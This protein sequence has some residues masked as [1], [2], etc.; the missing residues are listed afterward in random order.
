MNRI[1]RT[2]AAVAL[3]QALAFGADVAP[4][5][6]WTFE[7]EGAKGVW[8]DTGAAEGKF[9][10]YGE[11]AVGRGVDVSTALVS[12]GRAKNQLPNAM[13]DYASFTVDF[14]FRPQALPDAKGRAFLFD[15]QFWSWG[16]SRWSVALEGDGSLAFFA[17]KKDELDFKAVSAPVRLSPGKYHALRF[18]VAADGLF[19][20]WL[21]GAEIAKKA[22]APGFDK[23]VRSPADPYYP[24]L[25]MGVDD[26]DPHAIRHPFVGD[27]DNIRFYDSALGAPTIKLPKCDYS[28][29]AKVEYKPADAS[30]ADLLV[31]DGK[32]HA[33]T[34]RFTVMD[35]EGDALGLMVT[36]D[37]KFVDAAATVDFTVDAKRI[38]ARFVCPVPRGM[39][40]EKN[41]R[42]A[43]AGDG[44]ELFIRPDLAKT[45]YCQYSAN[46]AGK[47]SFM[48]CTAPDVADDSFTS[49]A[50]AVAKDTADGFE[51]VFTVPTD[52]VFPRGLKA[53]DVFSANFVRCGPTCS[54]LSTWAAV[55]GKFS[56]I[57]GFGK[58]VYGGSE[59][60]FK[61][62]LA[63]LKAN[64]QVL[65]ADARKAAV[66]A[67]RP[68]VEAV[69]A[70]GANPEAFVAIE[71]MFDNADKA[72]LQIRL[73]GMPLLVYE[74][75]D[76]WGSM[77]A[78]DAMSRPLEA[79]KMKL[80]RNGRAVYAFAVANLRDHAFLG[81]FKCCSETPPK[82]FSR[83]AQDGIAR[84]AAFYRG[85]P[86]WNRAGKE[87]YDPVEPLSMKTL[88]RLAP[89]EYAPMY[90]ELD[91][92]GLEPGVYNALVYLK[93]ATPG[94]EDVRFGLE[95]EVTDLDVAGVKLDKA[96]YDYAGRSFAGR[97]DATGG[98]IRLLCERDYNTAF[99]CSMKF[100]PKADKDG[101]FAMGPYLELDRQIDEYLKHVPREDLKLWIYMIAERHWY[102]PVDHRGERFPFASEKWAEGIRFMLKNF[103]AH[104]KEKYGIG[105]DRIW[106][107][108]VD[109]PSGEIEDPT[110][111]SK[112][113]VAYRVAQEIKRESPENLTMT[114]PLP[115]FLAS[116]DIDAA[117]AKLRE[118]YDIIELYR[119]SI[120]PKTKALMERLK[121][122]QVW[123]YSITTKET[124]AAK[125]RRDYWENM[126]DGYREIAAFWHMT[127]SAGGD[128]FDSTDWY[129]PG[130][131]DDYATLYC[132]SDVEAAI[133]SRRQLQC[134]QGFW[135][136]QILAALRA[137]HA[138]DAEKLA[139]IA[140]IVREAA[141]VG[142][143]KAMD[144]ARDRLLG[145]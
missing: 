15:Y 65:A 124:P 57:E 2:A 29:I 18:Q 75:N 85:F 102:D 45:A 92:R 91:A 90:L 46:A 109:E 42:N 121:F 139:A 128:T 119:P 105:P 26:T 127:Q 72:L 20:A 74:P 95:V 12:T 25:R 81:Q 107:Y 68:V 114:D 145:L 89:K 6:E 4:Q 101:K 36:A 134:D 13:M 8:L 132:N 64:A 93:K 142:T 82:D 71:T 9:N 141:D 30:G 144:A 116:K 40:A 17:T 112:I 23:L 60:Y 125:Y 84:K 58:V 22:G 77:I 11:T 86:V 51:V 7:S 24:L 61:N 70:H 140:E 135:D 129:S 34:R 99:V 131:L 63:A 54:G 87:L 110:W 115:S 49:R 123:S 21:D 103:K 37:R 111:K 138:G 41:E 52:E 5:H 66:E 67:C 10:F 62:R 106:W 136:M 56:N 48:R 88:V 31:L 59:A 104:V 94:Y 38:V 118:C 50:A 19:T 137:K 117:L 14:A 78:P 53:G 32:G 1:A 47:S 76:V 122:P 113:A 120:T 27:F 130:H 55:G 35:H 43:W 39:K 73:A 79:V 100:S 69:R 33:R 97:A 83:V 28:K 108:P 44:V 98:L 16:R 80:P 126:R 133:L 3:S 143:V 96:G